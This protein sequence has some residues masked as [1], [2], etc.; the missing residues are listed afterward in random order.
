LG[1]ST[2][3]VRITSTQTGQPLTAT[4]SFTIAVALAPAPSITISGLPGTPGP[5]TQPALGV[6]A[7]STY[8]IAIQGTVA[9]TFAPGSGPDDPNV[10]FTTGGRTVTFQIPAGSSQ[11]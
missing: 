11:A 8:P 10:Q 4:Q 7:G 2:F 9:L 6:T 3:T 5:A 1:T